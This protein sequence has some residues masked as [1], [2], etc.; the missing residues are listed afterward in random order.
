MASWT[1][2]AKRILEDE[3]WQTLR[4][5][6]PFFLEYKYRFIFAISCV[7][8]IQLINV[9]T[10]WLLGSIIDSLDINL[11]DAIAIPLFLLG[12]YVFIR[13]LAVAVAE[14]QMAVFG[15]VTVRATKN[16]SLKV[17]RHLHGLDLEYHLS[18]KTGGLTRDMDRGISAIT[19]LIQLFSL[20]LLG[21]LMG[22]FLVIG[23]FLAWFDWRYAIIVSVCVVIYAVYTV[24][25]TQ[26]RTPIIR[27]SNEAHSRAHTRAVDSLINHEN[28]KYFG[29]EELEHELYYHELNIWERARAKNRY[30]L[31]AL[32]VGQSFVVHLG[33]L[34]MLFIACAAIVGGELSLGK[35]VALNGYAI[36]VFGPLGALGSMYRRL[37]QAFT[38]VENMLAILLREPQVVSVPN[39]LPLP[40]G[41]GPI[42]FNDVH[43]AYRPDRPILKGVTFTVQPHERVALVGPSGAGKS[44]I[45]RLLFRFYDV[46]SGSIRVNGSDVKVVDLDG[47]R[48]AF[49][50]VPQDT[51]LFND[52]LA[53]NI[54]YGRDEATEEQIESVIKMA[55]LNSLIDQLPQGV[56][57]LVGERG[58]KLSGGEKQRVAIARTMLKNPS[59]LL[60]DEAT[61]SL[62]TATES[63]IMRAINEVSDGRTTLLIAHRL[64]TVIDADRII[65]LVDGKVEESGNHIQLLDKG[66]VY[67]RLWKLQHREITIE[68]ADLQFAAS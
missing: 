48:R 66:G 63:A 67:A 65:V 26:W 55:H 37:K 17:M 15:M 31:A 50:V 3:E 14:L 46:D 38:D 11:H 64:S 16:L 51:S 39:A 54:R 60:F 34:G 4:M 20:Q 1:L 42:E 10:P 47:L 24:K 5:L 68:E 62:D 59:F 6:F 41:E 35:L 19:G 27:A 30:S 7:G 53:Q 52:T 36:Q 58:L 45:A 25:I 23:I 18:R 13:F 29:N 40:Q 12:T 21:M 9:A 43:F 33:L 44:T 56:E 57:T 32:N 2:G 49:G 28:V 22:F 8:V 61:S